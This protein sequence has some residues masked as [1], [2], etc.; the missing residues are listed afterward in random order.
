MVHDLSYGPNTRCMW[1]V[2]RIVNQLLISA[3]PKSGTVSEG[4]QQVLYLEAFRHCYSLAGIYCIC[5]WSC[6]MCPRIRVPQT[7]RV[8]ALQV[9]TCGQW[10]NDAPSPRSP[11]FWHEILQLV[12]GSAKAASL[13]V[14]RSSPPSSK[15]S[16]RS[17]LCALNEVREVSWLLSYRSSRRSRV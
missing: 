2:E 12:S 7:S 17:L 9:L 10:A 14:N 16:Q 1:M 15:E 13:S 6:N 3:L 8:L 11:L 4:R 5:S